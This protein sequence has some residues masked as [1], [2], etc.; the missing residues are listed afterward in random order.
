M[1]A[2]V[3]RKLAMA[4]RV[5]DFAR[6]HPFGE[7]S[8]AQWLERLEERLARADTLAAQQR[9]GL[10]A[11]RGAIF[12][13]GNL[14]RKIRTGMLPHLVRVGEVLASRERPEL[15][16]RFR[17]LSANEPDRTFITAAKAMHAEAQAA[18]DAFV[19]MG[20]ADALLGELGQALAEFETMVA[21]FNASRREH[22]GARAELEAVVKDIGEVVGVLDGLNRYRFRD[23]PELLVVWNSARDVFGPFRSKPVDG[24]LGDG[25]SPPSGGV[26]PAA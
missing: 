19:R 23:N 9:D 10:I 1:D 26:A 21:E 8:Y 3:R 5:R 15:I 24:T 13:R 11:A 16:G 2:V 18:K 20:L 25:A 14:R 17:L 6:A 4:S 22:I 12:R 7:P